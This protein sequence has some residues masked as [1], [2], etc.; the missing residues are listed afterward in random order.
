MM[1]KLFFSLGAGGQPL[2]I[3]PIETFPN[4]EKEFH[5][6]EKQFLERLGKS[7]LHMKASLYM[8]KLDRDRLIIGAHF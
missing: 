7:P 6:L 3:S 8:L 4:A 1:K 2:F 5:F